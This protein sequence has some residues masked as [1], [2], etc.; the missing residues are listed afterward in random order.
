MATLYQG[1]EIEPQGM[2]F[3]W[4]CREA[5]WGIRQWAVSDRQKIQYGKAEKYFLLY[6][7]LQGWWH[8]R[9]MGQLSCSVRRKFQWIGLKHGQK[10]NNYTLPPAFLMAVYARLSV[11]WQVEKKVVFFIYYHGRSPK[12]NKE[13]LY[14]VNS[15]F[16]MLLV[17][18]IDQHEDIRV[19]DWKIENQ[20][21][22]WPPSR[23][24]P[25]ISLRSGVGQ[26]DNYGTDFLQRT[27]MDFFV[28]YEG[29]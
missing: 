14:M 13:V 16:P 2:R 25:H 9:I 6:W 19:V 24:L 18:D 5:V 8:L 3:L 11:R 27:Y 28:C 15:T 4:N 10:A 26:K 22:G 21:D 29:Q 1:D 20:L 7:F 12:I 17:F 23:Y